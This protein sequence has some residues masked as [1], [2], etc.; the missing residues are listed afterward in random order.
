MPQ[1]GIVIDGSSSC[2]VE[3]YGSSGGAGIGTG[4]G[5]N[6]TATETF[7]LISILG[8]NIYA[9]GGTAP[10]WGGPGIGYGYGGG[11][12]NCYI[13][14]ANSNVT[15]IGGNGAA[16]IG[17]GTDVMAPQGP[18]AG[19]KGA[20]TIQSGNVYAKGNGGGAGIGGGVFNMGGFVEIWSGTVYAS[21]GSI[22]IGGG[23]NYARGLL[24]LDHST[25]TPGEIPPIVFLKNGNYPSSIAMGETSLQNNTV[26]VA[27]TNSTDNTI[28]GVSLPGGMDAVADAPALAFASLL[29][30]SFNTNGGTSVSPCQIAKGGK[31]IS[32]PQTANG[33]RH[34]E[35]WFTDNTT[36]INQVTF[37]YSPSTSIDLYAQWVDINVTGVTISSSSDKLILDDN[38]TDNDTVDLDVNI[39]PNDANNKNVIWSSDNTSIAT[40]DEDG[41][42]TA[43][44]A[45]TAVITVT[46]DD[47]V[48]GTFYDT[49]T[50]TV[51]QGVTG[52]TLS[53]NAETMNPGQILQLSATVLPDDATYPSVMWTSSNPNVATV[54][55]TGKVTAV[56]NGVAVIDATAGIMQTSFGKSAQC[57]VTVETP[58]SGISLNS[59]AQIIEK[60]D[61]YQLVATVNPDD[62]SS[63]TVLWESSDL[64]VA[65]VAQDGTV[66]A[67]GE[68]NATITATADGKYATC[69]VEVKI[70][71]QS[72]NLSETSLTIKKGESHTLTAVVNPND[73]TYSLVVWE[74]SDISVATVNQLG[75]VTAVGSGESIITASADGKTAQCSVTTIV[76]VSGVVISSLSETVNR[77]S[78]FTLTATVS[79][80]NA[81]DKSVSWT[82]SNS[83]I[84]IVDQNGKVTAVGKGTASI[85]ATADG[86]SS[87]C[88]VIVVVN[89]EN[90]SLSRASIKMN[91]GEVY[92]LSAEVNPVDAT[93]RSII[94][95]SSNNGIATVDQNGNVS[96]VGSG[97]SKITAS[98][99]GKSATC[100]VTVEVAV[101]SISLSRSSLAL[102]IGESAQ[103]TATINPGDAT[104]Q[105]AEW[106]SSDIGV[107]EV[108]S[109]GLVIAVG[110]GEASVTVI[111]DGKSA[112]SNVTVAE[113]DNNNDVT[114]E[115][116]ASSSPEPEVTP[117]AEGN[118]IAEE[119]IVTATK[120]IN[121]DNR[122][123]T[124]TIEIDIS[125]LPESTSSIRLP[126]G[127]T[128]S[129]A[130]SN[131]GVLKVVI[132]ESEIS[133]NGEIEFVLIDDSDIAFGSIVTEVPAENRK[134]SI[135]LVFIVGLFGVSL[136]VGSAV[137]RIKYIN[138]R[139]KRSK[140]KK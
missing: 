112:S 57:T 111:I 4:Q 120:V 5:A 49:C 83:S 41:V 1:G 28:F 97:S 104:N 13:T 92:P 95:K 106:T 77:G 78:S 11:Q 140:R 135:W 18:T 52:I 31:I 50:I 25:Y 8:G 102:K 15:A 107:V 118:G 29:T 82:S 94:W 105:S 43:R 88:T 66:T 130:E 33:G 55:Y 91:K 3:A 26:I 2:E 24:Y 139:E 12:P 123:K 100:D 38:T 126:D 6:T 16:G 44:A 56:A 125:K 133:E 86:V 80:Q 115:K 19:I 74:S 37:P 60:G 93:D 35:G 46:A 101:S 14:L 119:V 48:N 65:T 61:T 10:S 73:A 138:A 36:F 62:A 21:G 7:S 116:E 109:N 40:V 81:D 76:P 51:E 129:L 69:G 30:V 45:G 79:P 90:I 134:T 71:V 32:S 58:V 68:G 132:A 70:S 54:D 23:N 136:I 47:T 59:S 63:P 98:S 128:I 96:A 114:V 122:S 85:S 137:A 113:E 110:S 34:F 103:L 127:E 84:A 89:V 108:S 124:I 99:G 39:L 9:E 87:A 72:I 121:V 17:G 53:T 67:L 20:I 27:N 64:S 117:S 131:N 22:D 75:E 42:V